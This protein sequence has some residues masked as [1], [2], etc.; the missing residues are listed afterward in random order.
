M[1]TLRLRSETTRLIDSELSPDSSSAA[2]TCAVAFA[3]PIACKRLSGLI[4]MMMSYQVGPTIQGISEIANQGLFSTLQ[5]SGFQLVAKGITSF[6]EIERV[7]GS[8]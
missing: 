7:S 6:D 8:D 4:P 2:S 5:Q 1:K 3:M